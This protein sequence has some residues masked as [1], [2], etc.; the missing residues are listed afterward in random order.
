MTSGQWSGIAAEVHQRRG[1]GGGNRGEEERRGADSATLQ[2]FADA[3]GCHVLNVLLLLVRYTFL[4]FIAFS[5][6]FLTH[7]YTFLLFHYTFI[8]LSLPFHHTHT[9]LSHIFPTI[10]GA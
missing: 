6:S 7:S 9:L 10:T 4:H 8:T 1:E 5:L 2:G 3:S